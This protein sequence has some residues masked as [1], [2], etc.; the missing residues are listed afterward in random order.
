MLIFKYVSMVEI[1]VNSIPNPNGKQVIGLGKGTWF[2]IAV[3]VFSGSILCSIS[4]HKIMVFSAQP[5][6][7]SGSSK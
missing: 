2:L 7:F 5:C 6:C 3:L 1:L 4:I